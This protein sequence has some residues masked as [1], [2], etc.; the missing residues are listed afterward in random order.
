MIEYVGEKLWAANLGELLVI[1]SVVSALLSSIYY[2]KGASLELEDKSW[3]KLGR[4]FFRIHSISFIGLIGLLFHLIYTNSFEFYYVWR[5]SSST[6]PMKYIISSFWEGQEGSTMLWG[7]WN[8]LLGNI[9]I[10]TTRKWEGAVMAVYGS[11]Q[12][13]LSAMLIGIY[14]FDLQERSNPFKIERI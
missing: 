2:I 11:V 7:F 5:H 14:V 4:L 8:A 13:F 6:M 10:Y 1:T 12:F 3:R 9:L